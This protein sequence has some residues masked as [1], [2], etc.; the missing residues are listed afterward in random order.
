MNRV[1]EWVLFFLIDR[2]RNGLVTMG[3][4]VLSDLDVEPL[5]E[6]GFV[7]LE[8]THAVSTLQKNIMA[9]TVIH[10]TENGRHYFER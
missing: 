9:T 5:V 2:E 3:R 6:S 8:Q 4:N 1:Q 10:L 7:T